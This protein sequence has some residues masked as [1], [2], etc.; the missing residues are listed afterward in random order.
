MVLNLTI[1]P[2]PQ[3]YR[4]NILSIC[5]ELPAV[6][7]LSKKKFGTKWHTVYQKKFLEKKDFEDSSF[8]E[9]TGK[10]SRKWDDFI[11]DELPRIN[12]H[13]EIKGPIP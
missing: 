3:D 4:E 9:I 7:K 11:K 12:S 5:Q 2:G 10:I 6:F 8:D 1:G 13:F